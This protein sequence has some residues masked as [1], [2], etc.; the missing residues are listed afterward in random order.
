MNYNT[1]ITAFYN[2]ENNNYRSVN[3]RSRNNNDHSRVIR[4]VRTPQEHATSY[5]WGWCTGTR[6]H[7]LSFCYVIVETA[8]VQHQEESSPRVKNHTARACE[9]ENFL[10][11]Q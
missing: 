4:P 8:A 3:D 9:G 7:Y 5:S 6:H 2:R 10:H 1:K 11:V